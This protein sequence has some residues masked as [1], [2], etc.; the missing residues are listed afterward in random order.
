MSDA[1]WG[2]YFEAIEEFPINKMLGH[3]DTIQGEMEIECELVTRG[4][5]I[6]SGYS[7]ND[8]IIESSRER[9]ADWLLLLQVDSN[10]DACKMM[11]GDV[12]RIYYWIRKQ[13]LLERDFSQTWLILQCS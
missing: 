12:G 5:Y 2:R 11:W 9:A 6:G 10:E 4:I 3:A 13:D 8:P 1:E 7:E